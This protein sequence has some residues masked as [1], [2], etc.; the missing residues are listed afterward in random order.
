[1][2]DNKTMKINKYIFLT[3]L[4]LAITV[5]APVLGA[6]TSFSSLSIH[7]SIISLSLSPGSTSVTVLSITNNGATPLPARIE[8]EPLA[9]GA[10]L[11]S[12]GSWV[13]ISNPTLL[14]PAKKEVT[15]PITITIPKEL[16]LG[17]YYGMLYVQ[18]IPSVKI[19]SDS[20]ISTKIGVLIL[21]SV[22][23]QD[24]PLNSIE[25]QKPTLTTYISETD[26]LNLSFSVQNTALN[27]I[28]T[29][30]YILIHPFLGKTE[31]AQ[32]DERLIFPGTERRWDTQFTVHDDK[33]LYYQAELFVALGNGR[34]KKQS[35]SFVIFPVKQAVVLVLCLGAGVSI[36]RKRKNLKK[37]LLIIING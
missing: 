13:H 29:K 30:P 31:S 21:G 26:T 22:G 23:V 28:S 33:R 34:F 4:F 32:F 25:L 7:P 6:E 16:P 11:H 3:I 18:S 27:H 1:M 37:A 14:I 15:V 5:S 8:F 20:L 10:S 24:I 35:F 2:S 12:I 36:F 9:L 19:S 17:G